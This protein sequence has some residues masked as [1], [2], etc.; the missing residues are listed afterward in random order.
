[1]KYVLIALAVLVV[2]ALVVVLG[3]AF[4]AAVYP[5]NLS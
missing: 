3:I 5:K 2:L 1:V 4:L